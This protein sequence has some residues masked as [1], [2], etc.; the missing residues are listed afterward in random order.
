MINNFVM[1]MAAETSSEN[2][3]RVV[4][5]ILLVLII[6]LAILSL[7]GAII[8]K[9]TNYQGNLL[10]RE[11]SD[12]IKK[13][14]IVREE[15]HFMK[16]ATKKN[17]L[18]FFKQSWIP[19]LI[20]AA[21]VGTLLLYIIVGDHWGYNPWSMENGFGSLLITWDFSTIVKV[22]PGGAA[23]VLVNWPEVSHV[24]TFDIKNWCGYISCTCWLVGGL[25]YLYAVQG[26]MGRTLRIL[27][28]K[29]KM[30]EKSLEDFNVDDAESLENFKS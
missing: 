25:W 28:L 5:T 6:A 29:K 10:D 12:P 22:N 11:I 17:K 3:K 24:P 19:L 4:Y 8:I 18:L 20:I 30:F 15:K 21:G 16:Y 13:C 27:H 26:L 1:A 7:I 2:T 9:V 14:R 23:G